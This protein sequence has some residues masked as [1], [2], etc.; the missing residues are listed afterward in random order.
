M[1]KKALLPSRVSLSLIAALSGIALTYRLIAWDLVPHPDV[2]NSLL[3]NSVGIISMIALFIGWVLIF[4]RR[5][6]SGAYGSDSDD[7]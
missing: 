1:A 6:G 5:P 3:S 7:E 4:R 2:E